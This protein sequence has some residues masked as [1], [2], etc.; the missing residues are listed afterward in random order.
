MLACWE[1]HFLFLVLLTIPVG[2]GN[3]EIRQA[4]HRI[5]EHV[6]LHF[7]GYMVPCSERTSGLQTF[8]RKN[9]HRDKWPQNNF[10]V[11]LLKNTSLKNIFNRHSLTIFKTLFPKFCNTL[12][13]SGHFLGKKNCKGKNDSS[14]SIQ[15]MYL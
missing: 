6:S 9:I 5:K 1:S 12:T 3:M 8:W 11:A 10:P 13:T 15:N 7:Q 2:F 4:E 14:D